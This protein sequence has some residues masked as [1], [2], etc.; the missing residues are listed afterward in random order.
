[1]QYQR[2]VCKFTNFYRIKTTADVEGFAVTVHKTVFSAAGKFL[3]KHHNREKA[4]SS[5]DRRLPRLLLNSV[6]AEFGSTRE[7]KERT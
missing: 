2:L 4:K 6:Y 5:P 3:R 1:M 7:S